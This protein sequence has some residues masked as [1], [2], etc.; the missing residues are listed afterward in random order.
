[1]GFFLKDKPEDV[2]EVMFA[3][4][5]AFVD[6]FRLPIDYKPTKY[7]LIEIY[8]LANWA[9]VV[10]LI[11]AGGGATTRVMKIIEFY[12]NQTH[13]RAIDYLVK[14]NRLEQT[15]V[16]AVVTYISEHAPNRRHEYDATFRNRGNIGDV[17]AIAVNY[18]V[19]RPM[20][21]LEAG[22]GKELLSRMIEVSLTEGISTLNK[23]V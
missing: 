21:E 13:L 20:S 22:Q 23:M 18:I 14:S 17:A 12:S 5:I 1:M 3:S 8:I 11:S 4:I 16:P 15:D 9:Q 2:A 7:N 6:S 19:N 10:S